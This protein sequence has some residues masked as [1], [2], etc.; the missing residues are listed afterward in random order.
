[1][2]PC[3]NLAGIRP[4]RL[5]DIGRCSG[6][7]SVCA[8]LKQS[9]QSTSSHI[10]CIPYPCV[11]RGRQHPLELSATHPVESDGSYEA[12]CPVIWAMPP[13]LVGRGGDTRGCARCRLRR[14]GRK[15]GCAALGGPMNATARQRALAP[16][17]LRGRSAW[18][19]QGR[20]KRTQPKKGLDSAGAAS[21]A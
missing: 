8:E 11:C 5:D 12:H 1:M 18:S 2:S 10:Q 17:R 20:E 15:G 21:S 3:F 4:G 19:R 14:A 6:R 9:R 16:G 7:A 13:T